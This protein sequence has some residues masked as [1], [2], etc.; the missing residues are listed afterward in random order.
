MCYFYYYTTNTFKNNII[1]IYF[2]ELGFHKVILWDLKFDY[3]FDSKKKENID[4]MLSIGSK[5]KFNIYKKN[6]FLPKDKL[7]II[8]YEFNFI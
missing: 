3:L 8:P 5:W 1:T 4:F 6:S 2:E 7:Y